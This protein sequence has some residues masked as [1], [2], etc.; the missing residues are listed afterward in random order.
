MNV[1]DIDSAFQIKRRGLVDKTTLAVGQLW[2]KRD[3]SDDSTFTSNALKVVDAASVATVAL[4]SS[5]FAHKVF[6]ET[7]GGFLPDIQL[8]AEDYTVEALRGVPAL[9]VYGRPFGLLGHMLKQGEDF[10]VAN[11]SAQ[12]YAEKLA[13][14]DVQLA[15]TNSA[16]DWMQKY[17]DT[18]TF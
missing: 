12:S 3:F 9:E 2:I 14:T 11:L 7:K 10:D 17:N 6:M 18:A 1:Q 5:F 4:V 8:D 13:A 15:H 16:R